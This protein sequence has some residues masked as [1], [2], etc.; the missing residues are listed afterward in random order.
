[1]DID[2]LTKNEDVARRFFQAFEK[3]DI[4]AARALLAPTASIGG[5]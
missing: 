1:M 2:T 5:R 3:G 4:V